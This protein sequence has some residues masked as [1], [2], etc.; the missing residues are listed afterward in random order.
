LC[1]SHNFLSIWIV[2]RSDP[3]PTRPDPNPTWPNP[4]QTC[5]D[6]TRPDPRS[7]DLQ[8]NWNL[9]KIWKNITC[10]LTRSDPT[11]TRPGPTWF[12]SEGQTYPTCPDPTHTDYH[13]YEMLHNLGVQLLYF[14]SFL[15]LD[16]HQLWIL[17]FLSILYLFHI[18]YVFMIELYINY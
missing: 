7:N 15:F 16:C 9:S 14:V 4:I 1:W 17:T 2:T 12:L 11:M 6:P 3:N 8:S 5:P 18:N 10:K 13:L